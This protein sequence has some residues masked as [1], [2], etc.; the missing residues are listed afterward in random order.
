MT[1]I[2]RLAA[3]AG[4]A[5]LAFTALPSG[6]EAQYRGGHYGP[7]WNGPEGYFQVNARACPDLLED[8]RDRRHSYGRHHGRGDWRDRRVLE[9]PIHAWTYIPSYNERRMGRT[10]D[11]LYPEVAYFDRHTGRYQVQTRWGDVP[12]EVVW[13]RGVGF[14]HGLQV[15]IWGHRGWRH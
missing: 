12:V 11:R 14:N 5:A 9:C 6:A 1:L 10:G 3:A 15:S 13:D 4:L 8:Y 7:S 2:A